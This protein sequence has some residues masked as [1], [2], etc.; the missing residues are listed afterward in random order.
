MVAHDVRTIVF[1]SSCA[2]Y[3]APL[4]PA[5]AEDHPKNPLSP[6]GHSKYMIEVVLQDIARAHDIRYAAL[7]YYNAAGGVPESGLGE[8][9][10]PETHIIPLLLDAAYNGTPFYVY[11][12]DY[13]TPDGTCIRDY[14]H[15]RDIADAHYKALAYLQAGN[16]STAFNIGSGL[17]C[18]VAELIVAVERITGLPVQ[19]V[20]RA[21]REGDPARLLA[22]PSYTHQQLGWQA[23][24]SGL[25]YIIKSL[26]VAR[27]AFDEQV[28]FKAY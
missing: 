21:R 2:V 20:L 3:G 13:P 24:H 17:G 8:H 19:V 1:S 22:D 4:T 18:S 12:N 7:R 28:K 26:V 14:V 10:K 5:F 11:G 25:E 6:Y 9:H 16:V 27:H 23:Q 15:V